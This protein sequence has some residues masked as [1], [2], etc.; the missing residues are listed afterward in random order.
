VTR[1]AADAF[2]IPTMRSRLLHLGYLAAACAAPV[3]VATPGPGRPD[4]APDLDALPGFH[5]PPPGYGQVAFYWW[6]GDPLTKER[7]TWQLDRLTG[8]GVSGLQI[9]YAHSDKGG[10]TY[11]LT[12]PSEPALFSEEWWSLVQGFAGEAGRRG[13]AVSLSDYTLG[14]GQGWVLDDALKAHPEIA[15][16]ELKHEIRDEPPPDPTP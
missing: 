9:N 11:G 4:R 15:G 1:R 7:L 16:A 2:A 14:I 10:P 13:M 5:T 12:H 8:I 3:A 6:L